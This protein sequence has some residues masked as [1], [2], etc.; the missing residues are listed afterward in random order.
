M[1]LT[2]ISPC[3]APCFTMGIH[4]ATVGARGADTTGVD[5]GEDAGAPG[6]S[7]SRRDLS[8]VP[9][10][11]TKMRLEPRL[12]QWRRVEH[13]AYHREARPFPRAGGTYHGSREHTTATDEAQRHSDAA[14][15]WRRHDQRLNQPPMPALM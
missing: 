4:S 1:P 15:A 2:G 14:A 7:S 13:A 9:S 6:S 3:A 11:R 12:V 5:A 10:E 8:I